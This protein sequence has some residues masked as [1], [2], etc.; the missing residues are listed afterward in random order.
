MTAAGTPTL[1]APP[2]T[3]RPAASPSPASPRTRIGPRTAG[4]IIFWLLTS[5]LLGYLTGPAFIKSLQPPPGVILDFYKE[6][7]SVKNRFT[8]RPVYTHQRETIR[9][10]LQTDLADPNAYFEEFN[11]HPPTAV[12]LPLPFY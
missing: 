3:D 2:P 6:W 10:Y 11:A 1:A 12:A 9:D 5:L 7:A 8:G 4:S